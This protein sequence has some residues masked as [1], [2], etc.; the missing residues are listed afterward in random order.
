MITVTFFT[1]NLTKL[2]HCRYIAEAYP[3]HI[4]GFRQQT[5]HADYEEPRS[6]SREELL[7]ASYRSA[8]DQCNKAGIPAE[9]R[10]FLLEDTSVRINA[11]STKEHAVPGLDIKYWMQGMTFEKLDSFLKE[12][13]NDRTACVRSDVLL[14]IPEELRRLWGTSDEYLVFDGEQPGTVIEEEISF[15]SNLVFPWLDNRTFNRWFVPANAVQP[16]GSMEI[17]KADRYDFRRISFEKALK[18]LQSKG[19]LRKQL[20]QPM[21]PVDSSTNFIICGY[22]CAGKTIAGQRL[23]R[24]FGYRHIEASDFMYL[25][26]YL[27]HG[28]QDNIQI[29][30]FAERALGARPEIVAEK[31]ADYLS[32]N[33]SSP[34]VVSGFR[35]IEEVNWLKK[36][37]SDFGK[38]FKLVFVQAERSIRFQ[39]LNHRRRQGDSVKLEQLQVTDAQQRRMGLG[40]IETSSY[41]VMW[42]NNG[43]LEAYYALVESGAILPRTNQLAFDDARE[44]LAKLPEIRLEDSILIALLSKWSDDATGDFFTTS[45][46]ASLIGDVFCAIKPKHKDNVSRYFNQAFHPDYEISGGNEIGARK[47]RLSN[48]GYSRALFVLNRLVRTAGEAR[49]WRGR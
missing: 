26:Y 37:S 34:I 31:V 47:F 23:A 17:E 39:R 4:V 21:L 5:Y 29:A 16:L 25:N 36:K 11:L 22:T 35:N 24:R 49:R 2:A 10:V 19:V 13:G 46:I 48:T 8:L 12:A 7:D 32:A 9:S 6:K 18:Y 27:R 44:Q 20:V 3:V 43:T 14:H 1:S 38:Q 42:Q 15:E 45:Q 41:A 40:E 33:W 30:D 28:Y